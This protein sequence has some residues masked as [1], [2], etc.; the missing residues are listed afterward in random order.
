VYK[1][2]WNFC[3]LTNY[4]FCAGGARNEV[5]SLTPDKTYY[6]TEFKNEYELSKGQSLTFTPKYADGSDV[7]EKHIYVKS[8]DCS[9]IPAVESGAA[10]LQGQL[11]CNGQICPN[12]Y[13][14]ETNVYCSSANSGTSN[15]GIQGNYCVSGI[16]GWSKGGAPVYYANQ[17]TSERYNGY[18]ACDGSRTTLIGESQCLAFST[19]TQ[20]CPTGQQCAVTATNSPGI[21]LG[22]CKCPASPCTVNPLQ[23][24]QINV[25]SYQQ[26]EVLL[27]GCQGWGVTTTCPEGAVFDDV[28][29]TC[30]PPISTCLPAEAE[31]VGDLIRSCEPTVIAGQTAYYWEP[32]A[33]ACLGEKT[34]D[35][36]GTNV[37]DD[38]CSCDKVDECEIDSIQCT[39]STNYKVCTKDYNAVNSCLLYRDLGN[40]VLGSQECDM[41]NNEIIERNDVG[42]SFNTP[43]TECST[44]KDRAGV[45]LE[46]CANNVCIQKNDNLT[47]TSADYSNLNTRCYNN[48]VQ[49]VKK[50]TIPT[51]SFYRWET[52]TNATNSIQGLCTGDYLCLEISNKASCQPSYEYVGII[53]KEAYGVNEKINNIKIDV[54]SNVP[55]K[56][57]IPLIVRLLEN[58]QE[59]S[60]VG[61]QDTLTN[62]NGTAIINF[63][64]APIKKGVLIIQVIAGDPQGVFYNAS[65]TINILPALVIKLNCPTQGYLG[66]VIECSWRIEDAE[67]SVLL[68]ANPVITITQGAQSISDYTTVAKTG[69]K[70]NALSLG[71]VDVEVKASKT[72]YLD[73]MTKLIVPVQSQI[74]TQNLYLDNVIINSLPN[75]IDVGVTELKLGITDQTGA[76]QSVSSVQ[77]QIK[78]PSG[79]SDTLQF[80][81]ISDD[82]RVNYNFQQ[83]KTTYELSGSIYLTDIS[84]TP[85][86]FL[87]KI[88]TVEAAS[89]KE[90]A[91]FNTAII[92][93][94]VV[95]LAVIVAMVVVIRFRKKR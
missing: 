3:P 83:A 92:S 46:S 29:K 77:A 10:C 68:D 50:Y 4:D 11:Q 58:G 55:N 43:G 26:C 5:Q 69:V 1:A 81:L 63:E 95:V 2:S 14:Y 20:S 48:Y 15:E 84:K 45:L 31:C 49:G 56:N 9:C 59:I 66:T 60:G 34:C 64:Y 76:R 28:K 62:N 90:Q 13:R 70:F 91:N 25:N 51:K 30:V 38:V 61:R 24:K 80:S 42:C 35:N 89:E 32:T 22:G 71:T 21:G 52:L 57:N 36:R 18:N 27:G 82:W 37:F 88:T 23:F 17:C 87:Y 79:A 39:N 41:A 7:T 72:D 74:I 16:R 85:I 6:T 33:K 54:T 94:I 67:T 47:S 44:Q 40:K 86:P 73:A 78:T 93:G 8:F 53:T 65:K 75:G 12:N 19:T